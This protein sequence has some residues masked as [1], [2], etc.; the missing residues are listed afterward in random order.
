MVGVKEPE[1]FTGQGWFL[2]HDPNRRIAT[3]AAFLTARQS[4]IGERQTQTPTLDTLRAGGPKE[5]T[6]KAPPASSEEF[7]ILLGR[8]VAD[9]AVGQRGR[10]RREIQ[11]AIGRRGKALQLINTA[12]PVHWRRSSGSAC[13]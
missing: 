1:V 11:A 13:L 12:G 8:Q 9:N 7:I 2:H 4:K 6:A 3:Q 10:F 5:F